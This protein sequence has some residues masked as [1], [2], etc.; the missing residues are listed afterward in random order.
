MTPDIGL[1]NWFR[2]R[3][4]RTPE[5]R[6]LH[7]EGRGWTYGQ[8]QRAIE[9]CAGRLAAIGISKGD[10]VAFLGNNQ[11]MFLF[12]MFA[13]ARLG[14]IFVP[15]NFRLT[16]PEIAFLIED[17]AASVI[18][19]DATH[20]AVI[21]PQLP[22]L[23]SLKATLAA[24]DEAHWIDGAPPRTTQVRVQEDD[25]ALIMYTSGTT[26][27][28]KGAMLTHGNI[29]WNNAS[30]MHMVDGLAD[31]VTLVPAPL[32]HIGGLNVTLLAAFQKG[33]LVVLRRTFDPGQALADIAAHKVTT[34]F[35]VPAMFLF[36]AQHPSFA[37]AD[38][39]SVR[40]L[41]VGGAPCPLPVLKTYL[42]RGVSLQQGYGLTEAAPGVS[43]LASEYA[44]TK[45][46]SSGRTP[47]FVEAKIVDLDGREVSSPGA[48]GEILVRGP[49]VTKGYWGLPD[50]TAKA[51]DADGWLHTGDAGFFDE[52]G[53]LT[54][55][56]RI[57]DMIITGGENVYP[58]EIESQ[59]MRHPAIAEVGVIGEPD[60]QWGER[61]V[62]V[63]ALKAGQ[64][65][66]LEELCAFAEPN[67]AHYKLPKRLEIVQALPRNATG[68]ILKRQL[69]ETFA[70]GGGAAAQQ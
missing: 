26:G 54:V 41:F 27:R 59:L 25:V 21:E 9:D 50:A 57:K 70:K 11:P 60:S 22:R 6:A 37:E 8:M 29:W 23:A 40:I 14:A 46:G 56:D 48:Q 62:A 24:E 4:L 64:S 16:G 47:M 51:I 3:A 68:K 38:L 13:A 19:V 42:A 52:D 15:L 1:A 45:V 35:G 65:L 18:I 66:S 20:R 58:A 5:R 67:L 55:S 10:R 30:G 61:V 12:A 33:A 17:C 63:V 44:L 53:F 7:F 69:R 43:F 2:E 32:F 34:M 49:N 36:M 28:P 31:D 39:S